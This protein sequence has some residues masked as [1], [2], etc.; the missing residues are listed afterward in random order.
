MFDL[1]GKLMGVILW[2][3]KIMAKSFLKTVGMILGL[4]VIALVVWYVLTQL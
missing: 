2:P 4:A 3:F 1:F